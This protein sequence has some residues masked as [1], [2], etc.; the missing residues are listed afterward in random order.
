M[1]RHMM[2]LDDDMFNGLYESEG[3]PHLECANSV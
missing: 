3:Q 1:R 2:Y